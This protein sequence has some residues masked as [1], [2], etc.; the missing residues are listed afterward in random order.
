LLGVDLLLPDGRVGGATPHGE[1]V[2][3]DDDGTAVDATAAE[4][5]VGRR[6][7]GQGTVL[8]DGL[9]GDGAD[10][11]ERA[12]VEEG[13]DALP[14]G[15]LAAVVLAGDLLGAAHA[16]G[17]VLGPAQLGDLGCPCPVVAVPH[18]RRWYGCGAAATSS[19]PAGPAGWPA[20]A[21]EQRAPPAGRRRRRR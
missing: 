14:N 7:V 3:A 19:A 6:Q 5:E 17:Q 15:E 11:V 16:P 8:V 18:G 21:G 1:V 13:V 10:L 20:P 12:R 4:D 9:A 2:P